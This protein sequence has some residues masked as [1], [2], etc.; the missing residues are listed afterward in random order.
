MGMGSEG[1]L[2]GKIWGGG[3]SYVPLCRGLVPVEKVLVE[4]L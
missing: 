2:E 4:D 3:G 1:A